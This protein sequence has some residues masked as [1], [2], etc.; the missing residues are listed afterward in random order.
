MQRYGILRGSPD[1][2]YAGFKAM[3][4]F[5]EVDL[6]KARSLFD[7]AQDRIEPKSTDILTLAV[8][9]PFPPDIS[10]AFKGIISSIVGV[11]PSGA[12]YY[13]PSDDTFHSELFLIKR[14]DETVSS[15]Q[16]DS[17]M[18]VFEEVFSKPSLLRVTYRGFLITPDGAIIVKGFADYES[19][20][21][22]LRERISFAPKGQTQLCHVSIGRIL[23]PLGKDN[24]LRLQNLVA[25]SLDKEYGSVTISKA[26]F[27][28]EHQWY[29]KSYTEMVTYSLLSE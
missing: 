22:Q 27:I 10:K 7:V 26:K 11:L 17:A 20:R 9:L 3:T 23:D 1:G 5:Q 8:G 18:A 19:V 13:A 12:R 16:I 21:S 15:E 25:D 24:F 28:H 29:M 14:P 4:D 2:M 6:I